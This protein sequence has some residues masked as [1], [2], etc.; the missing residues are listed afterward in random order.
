MDCCIPKTLNN[1][2]VAPS[3]EILVERTL[4]LLEERGDIY[5][6]DELEAEKYIED[7]KVA[8]G[9]VRYQVG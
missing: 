2:G 6:G 7:V 8:L 1:S 4:R 3:A 5:L 9:L